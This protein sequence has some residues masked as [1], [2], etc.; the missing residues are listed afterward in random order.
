MHFYNCSRGLRRL[1]HDVRKIDETANISSVLPYQ[2][3]YVSGLQEMYARRVGLVGPIP[4]ELG[5]LTSLRVLSMGNNRLCG[6]IPLSLGA[7]TNLQRIV[8]HQNNLTGVIPTELCS[9]GCIVNLAGNA[10]LEYG[11]D[12]P[13]SERAVLVDIFRSTKGPTSW[14][15]KH[16]WASPL[17]VCRWYK[18]GVLGSHV[19][20]LV[21]SSNCLTGSLPTSISR[22][23]H[24]RM[25][26]LAT[27]GSLT[28]AI[29]DEI[30]QLTALK[31]LCICRCGI[32][33]S[34]P[35][36][37]G[38]L[39]SLEELQLFGNSIRGSIPASIS[40]LRSLKLL[41]LGEYTGGNSFDPAPLPHAL[42]TLS[43]LEALFMA[44]CNVNGP[45]P[46]WIGRLTELRQL[47]LQR[48]QLHGR[49]PT[50]IELCTNLLYLNVKDNPDFGG[51]IPVQSLAKLKKLNRLSLV[52]CS[53]SNTEEALMVLADAIPKCKLWL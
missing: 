34:I 25:I 46:T 2:I 24:L 17:P 23:T 51:V 1:T 36:K 44:N 3:G 7:L 28:G 22:L 16:N 48:N 12:V 10:L 18:V 8:L 50:S 43:G 27:M 42:S 26:E 13:D 41:S 39:V 4:S 38:N 6:P 32:K 11:E 33:G 45:L 35:S 31:R 9:L 52:H 49:F 14:V 5:E 53:F 21:M 47:D 40:N 30:C 29:P 20:S 15:T 19:H 37:I